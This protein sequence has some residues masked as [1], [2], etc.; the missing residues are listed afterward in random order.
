M[1]S[2]QTLS[3]SERGFLDFQ[4]KTEVNREAHFLVTVEFPY[5]RLRPEIWPERLDL[6]KATGINIVGFLYFLEYV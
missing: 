6:V 5:Y 3:K 2:C 4:D 1:L